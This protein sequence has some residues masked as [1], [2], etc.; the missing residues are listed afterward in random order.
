VLVTF[1]DVEGAVTLCYPEA[2][3]VV[4]QTMASW[5]RASTWLRQM[6]RLKGVAGSWRRTLQPPHEAM[7]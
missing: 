4:D 7:T 6:E 1:P 5:N 3:K 2:E